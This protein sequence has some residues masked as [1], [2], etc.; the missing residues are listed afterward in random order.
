MSI[1]I[2]IP[3]VCTI[4]SYNFNVCIYIAPYIHMSGDCFNNSLKWTL[5]MET[6]RKVCLLK[7]VGKSIYFIALIFLILLLALQVSCIFSASEILGVSFGEPTYNR[8]IKYLFN[9][10]TIHNYS[11]INVFPSIWH[12]WP[13]PLFH[14]QLPSFIMFRFPE[15]HWDRY[16]ARQSQGMFI[17]F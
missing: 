14:S 10:P 13:V 11:K 1:Q 3:E 15:S 8:K 7:I 5:V 4:R 16:W 6:Q 2:W 12:Q 17:Q 9:P